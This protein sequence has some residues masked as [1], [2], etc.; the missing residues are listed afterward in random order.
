MAELI[1]QVAGKSLC[2]CCQNINLGDLKSNEGYIHQS[3]F[4]ALRHSSLACGLCYLIIQAVDKARTAWKYH[5]FVIEDD[6][7][8]IRL[9]S[10]II[11][12]CRGEYEG[13]DLSA[14]KLQTMG[15][16]AIIIGRNVS[17]TLAFGTTGARLDMFTVKGIHVLGS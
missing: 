15:K 7:G 2:I 11:P 13:G 9:K 5:H 6:G 17:R 3:T 12:A 16:V 14:K 1:A 8:P 4:A 10:G